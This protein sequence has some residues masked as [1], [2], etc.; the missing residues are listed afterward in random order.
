MDYRLI[1]VKPFLEWNNV[2]FATVP[3][4]V[5]YDEQRITLIFK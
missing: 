5:L 1:S 2:R 4:N 3:L